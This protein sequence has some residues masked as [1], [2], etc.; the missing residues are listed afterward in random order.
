MPHPAPAPHHVAAPFLRARSARPSRR[1][2]PP[3]HLDANV[4]NGL[5]LSHFS[6]SAAPNKAT[7]PTK[8]PRLDVANVVSAFLQL[9]TNPKSDPITKPTASPGHTASPVWPPSRR[10]PLSGPGPARA[11]HLHLHK[12]LRQP[13]IE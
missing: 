10:H 5:D 6:K 2:Q 3:V 11:N 1:L 7:A 8:K 13:R 4:P 12:P 9:Q